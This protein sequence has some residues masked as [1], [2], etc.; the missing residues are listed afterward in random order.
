M[1][2]RQQRCAMASHRLLKDGRTI[3]DA[4]S[5]ALSTSAP[6]RAQV[7]AHAFVR[8]PRSRADRS[9]RDLGSDGRSSLATRSHAHRRSFRGARSRRAL[10]PSPRDSVIYDSRA[11]DMTVRIVRLGT[12]RIRGEGLRIGTV[13][14]PPRGVPK[15]EHAA[16][17]WYDVWLPELAPSAQLVKLGQAAATER[18]LDR[19][20]EAVSR[21]DGG[22]REGSTSRALRRAVAPVR[23]LDGLLLRGRSPLPPIGVAHAPGGA[24]RRGR[25]IVRAGDRVRRATRKSISEDR[26]APTRDSKHRENQDRPR[27][28]CDRI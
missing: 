19:L 27:G 22:S 23:L 4:T 26:C 7:D 9:E 10:E 20:R 1:S 6:A 11:R 12:A 25:L 5:P 16:Q 3:A 15:S 13:R 17:N 24:R 18:R 8:R 21:G 14:R 2:S 28:S